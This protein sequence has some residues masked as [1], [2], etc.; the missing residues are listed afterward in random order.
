MRR[1][2]QESIIRFDRRARRRPVRLQ[3]RRERVHSRAGV[4][5]HRESS[6]DEE[7]AR[8]RIKELKGYYGHLAS[9]V[10]VNLFLF[11]LNMITSPGDIWFIYPLLGWGIGLAIHTFDVFGT[12]GDWERRKLDKLTGRERS[13]STATVL[14]KLSERTDALVTIL[15]GVDW[16]RIDPELAVTRQNLEAAQRQLAALRA[17]DDPKSREAL[18]R[19][20]ERLEKFVTSSKFNYYELASRQDG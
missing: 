8:E 6:V 11:A 20:I 1:T 19:E 15:S 12:G 17:H 16:E 2:G 9:Y 14:A 7:Q 5:E 13:Q 3:H 10:A 4:A 18:T